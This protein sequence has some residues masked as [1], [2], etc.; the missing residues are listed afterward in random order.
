MKEE[1]KLN[2]VGGRKEGKRWGKRFSCKGV[3][4]S[5]K[6]GLMSKVGR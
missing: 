1:G 3:K 2:N 5:R 6:T 4:E